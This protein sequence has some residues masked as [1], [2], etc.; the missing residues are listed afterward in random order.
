MSSCIGHNSNYT[1][2]W[3]HHIKNCTSIMGRYYDGDIEGKF[4]FGVQSS[5]AA[6]RFGGEMI[7]PQSVDFYFDESHLQDIK[8]ELKRIEDKLG[9]RLKKT[10]DFFRGCISYNSDTLKENGILETDLE[11]YADYILGNKIKD[12]VEAQGTCSFTAGL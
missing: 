3:S 1:K 11:D 5:V 12:C 2:T 6:Q 7:E 9:D 8:D 4:W 10:D